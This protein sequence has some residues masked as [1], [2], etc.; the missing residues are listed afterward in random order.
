M[1]A[2]DSVEFHVSFSEKLSPLP[3]WL[4]DMTQRSILFYDN[5]TILCV[6]VCVSVCVCVC[7][8][9]GGGG[10]YSTSSVSPQCFRYEHLCA[11]EFQQKI[12]LQGDLYHLHIDGL[13]QDCSNSIANALEL[14]QSC[15]KPLICLV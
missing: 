9:G 3:S 12:E 7:V 11:F 8:G 13:V 14:L 6:F 5:I 15:A 4:A 10:G 1:V 2:V